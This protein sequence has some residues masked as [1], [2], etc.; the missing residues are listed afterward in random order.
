MLVVILIHK[1][2]T[3]DFLTNTCITILFHESVFYIKNSNFLIDS[4]KEF[5]YYL[6]FQTKA[7]AS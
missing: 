7:F 6:G 4:V 3:H 1:I 5:C 2:H